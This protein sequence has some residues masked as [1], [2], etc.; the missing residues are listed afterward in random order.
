MEV[1][2]IVE[3]E[4][5]GCLGNW[6]FD[7]WSEKHYQLKGLYCVDKEVIKFFKHQNE[8]LVPVYMVG[9]F[10]NLYSF[11]FRHICFYELKD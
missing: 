9:V 1:V 6:V 5:R 2:D 7:A 11:P 4:W 3:A 10:P 8:D